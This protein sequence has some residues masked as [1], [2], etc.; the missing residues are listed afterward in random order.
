MLTQKKILTE[1]R[2]GPGKKKTWRRGKPGK[3]IWANP[4]DLGG[5]EITTSNLRKIGGPA[6][7][8]SPGREGT[9][10]P[11]AGGKAV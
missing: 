7:L 10:A 2:F 8:Y 3:K 5:G 4:G 1:K 11:L 9:V 6:D